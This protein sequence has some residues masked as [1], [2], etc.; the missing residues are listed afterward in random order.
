MAGN[1]DAST[2][3]SLDPRVSRLKAQDSNSDGLQIELNGG[4]Y[5]KK[6]QRAVIQLQCDKDRT[7]NEERRRK[8]DDDE[9]D[10]K[11]EPDP[12]PSS[13]L[14]FVSYGPVEGKEAIE[15]VRF[16][17]RTK[18]ACEDYADS[19]EAKKTGW[20]FF[21]WFIL[22]YVFPWLLLENPHTDIGGD[23]AF[24]GIAAYLIF[25][26]WLNYNRYGARGWD[27]LPHGDTLRD[28]PYLVKDFSRKVVDT[29]SGG[30]SRGGYSAV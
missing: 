1:F 19:D 24:L 7:G 13:S 18:Y 17:W 5:N 30:G 3:T 26:S 8:R 28:L 23:S 9:D 14:T 4:Y 27:L 11:K 22:L 12:E 6:K 20:G 15:V 25:G 16:N 21:T 2:G 10:D 29:V